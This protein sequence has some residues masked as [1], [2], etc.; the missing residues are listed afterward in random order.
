MVTGT[1]K[2]KHSI[3][4]DC[5]VYVAVPKRL[6]ESE[7]LSRALRYIHSLKPLTIDDPRGMFKD[8]VE[9]EAA[10]P[11]YLRQYNAIV[12]VTDNALVGRGVYVEERDFQFRHLPRFAYV[13]L[14]CEGIP[15][16]LPIRSMRIV[17]PNKWTN[18]AKVHYD[19]KERD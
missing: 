4:H 9:W 6:Y 10:F 15:S 17:N 1:K 13:E 2:V 7:I 12:V 19:L 14:E 3:I 16:L 11:T 5:N 18:Y 8:N